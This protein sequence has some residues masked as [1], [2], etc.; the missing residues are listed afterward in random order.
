MMKPGSR[1]VVA[2]ED[3]LN[4]TDRLGLAWCRLNC[5]E[6]DPFLGDEPRYW[7][8]LPV[9]KSRLRFWDKRPALWQEQVKMMRSIEKIIGEANVSRCWW[10][11][12]LERTETEW[13]Y[14]YIRKDL[15]N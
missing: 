6:W 7:D 13:L 9:T 3:S 12:V 4:F 14:W 15:Q 8:S 2:D 1:I 11:F 10:V 5:R